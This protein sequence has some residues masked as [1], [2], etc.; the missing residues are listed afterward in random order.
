MID[1]KRLRHL[2]EANGYTRNE[3]AAK[4]DIHPGQLMRYEREES[5]ATTEVLGRIANVL[6][7]SA[8]YLIGLSDTPNPVESQTLQPAEVA[9]IDALRRKD[10]LAVFKIVAGTGE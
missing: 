9:L 10:Y 7:V 6:G 2:R 4:I 8:D 3:L 5:D 1:G